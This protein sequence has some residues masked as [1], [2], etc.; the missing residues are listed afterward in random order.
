MKEPQL[1]VAT[2][3]CY[4]YISTS[5]T[6]R[7]EISLT[8]SSRHFRSLNWSVSLPI[9]NLAAGSESQPDSRNL[10]YNLAVLLPVLYRFICCFDNTVTPG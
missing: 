2:P 8:L 3:S 1:H 10:L 7:P 6:N 9:S 5:Y 4:L